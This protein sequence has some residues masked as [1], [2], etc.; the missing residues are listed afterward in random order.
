MSARALVLDVRKPWSEQT[1]E[2]VPF[3]LPDAVVFYPQSWSADGRQLALTA[4]G[5]DPSA[6]TYI[7]DFATQQVQKVSQLGEL[8]SGAR[9][10]SD[11]RRLLVGYQG[12]LHLINPVAGTTHEVLTVLPD[13]IVGFSLSRDDRLIVYGLRSNSADIWLASAEDRPTARQR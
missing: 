9:W 7:Y 1:P 3:S 4:V 13:D 11:N 8:Q 6:G 2:V 5:P 10:L 12:R